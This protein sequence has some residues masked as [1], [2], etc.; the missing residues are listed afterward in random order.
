MSGIGSWPLEELVYYQIRDFVDS[1]GAPLADRIPREWFTS[2][3]VALELVPVY[4]AFMPLV[5][6]NSQQVQILLGDDDG[7]Q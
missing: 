4:Q 5:T 1:L 2:L 3:D 7:S 6:L